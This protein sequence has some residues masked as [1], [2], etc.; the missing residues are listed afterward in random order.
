MPK[1]NMPQGALLADA[2]DEWD[3]A[4]RAANKSPATRK[5]Y[6][7][8]VAQLTTWLAEHGRPDATTDDVTAG[9][10]RGYLAD[11]LARTSDSTAITRHGGLQAFWK[12][13]CQEG[14]AE[15]D[16]TALVEKP[17]RSMPV[18]PVLQDD[19]VKAILATC[20]RDFYGIRDEAVIRML[21]GTGMRRGE[22]AGLS[23][24]DVDLKAQTAHIVRGKGGKGRVVYF[25]DHT[26]LALRRYLRARALHRLAHLEA[27]WL[28]KEQAFGGAG[29]QQ[30]LQ[31]RAAWA[32]V[33]RANPHAWRHLFAHSWLSKGGTE[34]SLMASAGWSNRAMI[35]RYGRSAAAGRAQ[36][37]AARL[38][39]GQGL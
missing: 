15:T 36:A 10:V 9:E 4:M 35:D 1:T 38:G 18:V 13:C 39:I 28:G 29:I 30:M 23:L 14:L 26:A 5:V 11:V 22:C 6:G 20:E 34:G 27:L 37:E 17:R 25:P 16:P 33:E 8:A 7:T 2:A 32:G 3:L 24:A 12:W 19:Q 21:L 31:R